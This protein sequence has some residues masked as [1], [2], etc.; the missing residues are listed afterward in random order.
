[1]V[2]RFWIGWGIAT[3]ASVASLLWTTQADLPIGAATV[4]ALGLCL[5]VVAFVA[6]FLPRK[7]GSGLTPRP[8]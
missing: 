1:M 2:K 6:K 4:C 3:F 8:G 7:S 5:V